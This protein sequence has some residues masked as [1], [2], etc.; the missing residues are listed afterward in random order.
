MS[1]AFDLLTKRLGEPMTASKLAALL[2]GAPIAA[3]PAP[4]ARGPSS[5]PSAGPGRACPSTRSAPSSRTL[6][7]ASRATLF[8]RN[9]GE[10]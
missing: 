7:R 3:K 10:L 4:P 1:R 9:S 2:P 8:S 5:R 6:V